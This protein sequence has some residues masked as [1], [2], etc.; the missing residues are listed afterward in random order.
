MWPLILHVSNDN[1]ENYPSVEELDKQV[2]GELIYKYEDYLSSS[3]W[4]TLDVMFYRTYEDRL[5][6]PG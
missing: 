4:E 3:I 5:L 1:F 2:V 6:G